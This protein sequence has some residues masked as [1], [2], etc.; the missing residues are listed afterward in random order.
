LIIQ[1]AGALCL[2]VLLIPF[3]ETWPVLIIA[4]AVAAY[5]FSII[6]PALNS[7]ISLRVDE[8]NQGMVMGVTRSAT[9]LAR[10]AGPALAGLLFAVMGKDWPYYAGAAS[11]A[12]VMVLVW[13]RKTELGDKEQPAAKNVNEP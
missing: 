8:E 12:T 2:G 5:G 4:M 11:M 6:S 7:A 9:T 10:V 1:G 13:H 3:A